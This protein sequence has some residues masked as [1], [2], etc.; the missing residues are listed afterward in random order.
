VD[1]AKRRGAEAGT[2]SILPLPEARI[3]ATKPLTIEIET[4]TQPNDVAASD[5]TAQLVSQE[6]HQRTPATIPVQVTSAGKP[7]HIASN[8]KHQWM[9][10]VRMDNQPLDGYELSASLKVG[11]VHLGDAPPVILLSAVPLSLVASLAPRVA[12]DGGT[13]S[14][15]DIVTVEDAQQEVVSYAARDYFDPTTGASYLDPNL[16]LQAA[17]GKS[18][19]LPSSGPLSAR[20]AEVQK[21]IDA[22]T[23]RGINQVGLHDVVLVKTATLIDDQVPQCDQSTTIETATISHAQELFDSAQAAAATVTGGG[24]VGT[25]LTN[26]EVPI[27]SVVQHQFDATIGRGVGY[28]SLA[29]LQADNG[30]YPVVAAKLVASGQTLPTGDLPPARAILNVK[31]VDSNWSASPADWSWGDGSGIGQTNPLPLYSYGAPPGGVTLLPVDVSTLKGAN[32]VLAV[33]VRGEE[34]PAIWPPTIGQFGDCAAYTS[35]VTT[36]Q[37]LLYHIN[38]SPAVGVNTTADTHDKNPGGGLCEDSNGKCSLRA[39]IEEDNA[40]EAKSLKGGNPLPLTIPFD[41]GGSGTHTINLNSPLP[42]L[43]PNITID[44]TS[45]P[46]YTDKP[47]IQLLGNGKTSGLTLS[48]DDVLRGLSLGKFTTAVTVGSDNRLGNNY[49]GLAPDGTVT[50]N[51]SGLVVTGLSNVIG[52]SNAI[53]GNALRNVVSGNDFGILVEGATASG[54]TIAQNFMGT[55]PSGLNKKGNVLGIEVLDASNNTISGNLISGNGGYGIYVKATG[56]KTKAT[57]SSNVIEGNQI[58]A[59]AAADTK[60]LG[61]GDGIVVENA[62]ATQIGGPGPAQPN[63]VVANSRGI[64]VEGGPS[65]SG[66]TVQGNFIGTNPDS[67]PGLGNEK[68]GVLLLAAHDTVVGGTFAGAGNLISGNGVGVQV[69]NGH[70]NTIQGNR[71]GTTADGDHKLANYIGVQVRSAETNL[72]GVPGSDSGNLISGN[73]S[74]GVQITSL[75]RKGQTPGFNQVQNNLIGTNVDGTAAVP[76]GIGAD[77]EAGASHNQIGGSGAEDTNLISGN[78]G[79]GVLL[80]G[81]AS[82]NDIHDNNIGTNMPGTG[83]LPNGGSRGNRGNGIEIS[84]A[85]GNQVGGS[86]G[87]GNTISGNNKDGLLIK[88]KSSGTQVLGNLIGTYA[89]EGASADRSYLGNADN[90]VEVVDATYEVIGGDLLTTPGGTCTG[91]CNDISGNRGAGVAISGTAGSVI[92]EG[93]DI[94]VDPSGAIASPNYDG[95]IITTGAPGGYIGGTDPDARDVISGNAPGP[96]LKL[97]DG[98]DQVL[99]DFIGTDTTGSKAIPNVGGGI[100]VERHDSVITCCTLIGAFSGAA[101]GNTCTGGCNLISGNDAAGIQIDNASHTRLSRNFIG[102]TMSGAPDLGNQEFGVLDGGAQLGVEVGGRNVIAGNPVGIQVDRGHL[103]LRIS[104]NSIYANTKAGI[105]LQKGGGGKSSGNDGEPAPTIHSAAAKGGGTALLVSLRGDANATYTLEFFSSPACDDSGKSF[106]GSVS[107]NVDE[108]GLGTETPTVA[109]ANAGQYITATS[110][111]TANNT[112]AF[113]KCEK[114]T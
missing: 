25:S 94:G 8:W 81:G 24:V 106:L 89:S 68:Y 86:S 73:T 66:N 113:S 57:A 62:Q 91:A 76:N 99:G 114:V 61:N 35:G 15:Y 37:T 97:G 111:S 23:W 72:I 60:P 10:T 5:I 7:T 29:Q 41:I 21:V 109:H 108:A 28:I 110:T 40:V 36:T 95:G 9:A 51:A 59:S 85:T 46:G 98:H 58:G 11:G 3:D 16:L 105:V 56:G 54:N 63:V 47:L 48:S 53:S 88:G 32:T 30:K 96:G 102:T 42:A 45:Q 27:D 22:L 100:L 33:Q 20:V 82:E 43:E 104:E 80:T 101:T 70:G 65:A 6:L 83:P 74:I 31:P 52:G 50:K 19:W 44:A 107:M 18:Q 92:V 34:P 4:D 112:S 49:V 77:I 75:S 17:L 90:G 79:D 64:T 69:E 87:E 13:L 78:L 103:G 55:D 1:P 93:N 2:I 67:A 71:I 38:F 84:D 12:L 39:A 26:E 14:P